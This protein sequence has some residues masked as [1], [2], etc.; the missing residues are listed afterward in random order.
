VLAVLFRNR[1]LFEITFVSTLVGAILCIVLFGIKYEADTQILVKHRRADEVVS[2]DSSSRDQISSTDVPTE[3]EINTE[4]SLLKGGDLMAA[5]AKDC[6]LDRR[7]NHVWNVLFPGRDENW[8]VAKAAK[9]LSDDL[10]IAEVPQSNMIQISYRSGQPEMAERVVSDLDRL[11]LA[12]HLAVNRPPKVFD[13]FHDQTQ[14]YQNEL[15]QAEAHLASYDLDKNASDPDLDKEILLRKA[16]EFEGDLQQTHADISQ[17][18][19]QIGKLKNL[20]GQTPDRMTTQVTSGD[21]PQLLA[22]LKSNLADLE[23]KRTDLLAKYQ[24]TYRLVQEVDK[25][26]A[27][28]GAAIAAEGRKPVRQESTGENP[29]YELLKAE[30]VKANKDL[31]GFT[32]RARA[33]AP[34]VETYRQQALLMDQ[35]GILR[36]DLIRNIKA[37]EVNYMLYVQKQEQ[38]RISDEMDKNSILNVTIAEAPGVP[39]LPVFS[40]LLLVLAGAVLAVM[41]STAV[42]FVTDYLDPSLRTPGEVV[43]CLGIPLLACFAKNGYPPRLGLLPGGRGARERLF[44]GPAQ[45]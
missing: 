7:E 41:V 34:V 18:T 14:H 19:E 24:P 38:A 40:P 30:L 37:A 1:R 12:K 45:T 25:Q 22:F 36:Q 33:T 42:A 31:T 32:A 43:E 3:R 28:L 44:V 21:N 15:E 9:K 29:T 10:K 11:Y 8:R 5:V 20:L 13:F 16:G 27:D 35:K 17:T 39:A 4:I 2:T 23:T 26:I 6:G